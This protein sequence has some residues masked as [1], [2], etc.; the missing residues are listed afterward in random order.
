MSDQVE[1]RDAVVHIN[2]EM[3]IY[4]ATALKADLFAALAAEPASSCVDL[5]AVP[6]IDTT[7]VQLLIMAQRV[8]TARGAPLSLANPSVAV[9]EAL[10]LLRILPTAVKAN[11]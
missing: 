2:G 6:E 3:T 1:K 8:C 4:S 9:R 7:G 5:A 11:A 10:E